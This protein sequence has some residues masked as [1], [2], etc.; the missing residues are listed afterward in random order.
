M[1]LIGVLFRVES[2][3]ALNISIRDASPQETIPTQTTSLFLLSTA[4]LNVFQVCTPVLGSDQI[5]H[6]AVMNNASAN[7][8]ALDPTI[9]GSRC[10]VTLMEFSFAD[11]F[12]KPFVGKNVACS[13]S[14]KCWLLTETRELFATGVH[15]K[16]K[17]GDNELYC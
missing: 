14:F 10:Q 17:Y 9:T 3:T 1:F 8:T 12:G 11:S 13:Q 4:V 6:Y 2:V 5:I 16:R 7:T 15:R